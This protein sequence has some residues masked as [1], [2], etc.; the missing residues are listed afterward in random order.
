[1]KSAFVFQ[2]LNLGVSIG[3]LLIA[4]I[5][6]K[7]DDYL[8]WILF[9]TIGSGLINLESALNAVSTRTISRAWLDK[10]PYSATVRL[11]GGSY[12]RFSSV[13]SIFMAVS[14]GLY[15]TSVDYG[16]EEYSWLAPW[17]IFCFAYF[18]YYFTS[19]RSCQLVAIGNIST[20]TGVGSLGRLTNLVIAAALAWM[21][22]G[23]L[24]LATAVLASFALTGL[25]LELAGRKSIRQMRPSMNAGSAPLTVWMLLRK[26]GMQAAFAVSSYFLYRGVFLY[27]STAMPSAMD[28]ASL[29]LAIQ[30]YGFLL[31]LAAV[32]L[33][34][35]I[36]PLI[37]AGR[38]GDPSAIAAELGH[39]GKLVNVVF[40]VASVGLILLGPEI[41][42][43]VPSLAATLPPR[44][45]LAILALCF[46]LEA[47]LL[48]LINMW[49]AVDRFDFVRLYLSSF[50]VAW[51]VVCVTILS[52]RASADVLLL[53]VLAVQSVIAAPLIVQRMRREHG[54]SLR[55]YFTAIWR[56]R[57]DLA[58]VI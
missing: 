31:I 2:G 5:F 33:N 44:S 18:I 57:L 41:F 51:F 8:L 13:G 23:L 12:A 19:Y 34:M 43:L 9:T 22:Y 46:W 24:G 7:T 32:P 16:A 45:T 36:A 6:L 47:N 42:R 56:A 29:G 53:A 58:A 39:L 40:V 55:D 54:I 27:L 11:V 38:T 30:L 25:L 15:L 48:I 14:G 21:G 4:L 49:L 35:R 17:I 10:A 26:S 1:V 50:A 20:F 37:A 52:G 28:A 3:I